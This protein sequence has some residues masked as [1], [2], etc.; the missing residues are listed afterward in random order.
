[1]ETPAS[2]LLAYHA[3]TAHCAARGEYARGPSRLDWKNQPV[4]FRRFRAPA[5]GEAGAVRL[6]ELP[7]RTPARGRRGWSDTLSARVRDTPHSRLW[8][9]GSTGE[10]AAEVV[11]IESAACL[12]INALGLSGR[13]KSGQS[14]WSLRC[15]PSSGN[16]HP[17]EAYV[18]AGNSLL[19]GC[20]S[21]ESGRDRDDRGG[22]DPEFCGH[23]GRVEGGGEQEMAD[24]DCDR[25]GYLFHYEPDHHQL[26]LRASGTLAPGYSI[27]RDVLLV[28]LSS[29]HWREEWKYG[30]RALRYCYLDTGHAVGAL[31][32][33]AALLGWDVRLLPSSSQALSGLLGTDRESDFCE[34]EPEVPL[35]LLACGARN[36]LARIR[37]PAGAAVPAWGSEVSWFGAANPLSKQHNTF[38]LE[39]PSCASAEVSGECQTCF[40]GGG[41]AI[42][43]GGAVRRAA[44]K[45]EQEEEH[46]ADGRVP[47]VYDVIQSRRSALEMVPRQSALPKVQFL[48]MIEHLSRVEAIG[49]VPPVHAFFFAHRV[50]G[51]N[52]GIYVLLRSQSGE[53]PARPDLSPRVAHTWKQV[54]APLPFYQLVTGD[55]RR[56]AATTACVQSIAGN[57]TFA[58]AMVSMQFHETVR[59]CPHAYRL[60]HYDAGNVIH[61]L[62]LDSTARGYATTG[63]GC[64]FDDLVAELLGYDRDQAACLYMGAVGKAVVDDRLTDI[65]PYDPS[66]DPDV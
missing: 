3:R 39:G 43:G 17:V 57:G 60:A 49:S 23:G 26:C 25:D 6:V 15:N 47:R 8:G 56:A 20:P 4:A 24:R 16:L 35:L 14:E 1:M 28:G 55:V 10:L 46:A 37:C 58:V 7:F 48:E 21:A 42:P 61:G 66:A 34:S 54:A 51:L 2:R 5:G 33:S 32:A 64:Y 45:E 18:L 29:I 9:E 52:P 11:S 13:K 22:R 38:G 30:E 53:E 27:P 62:Y 41:G 63:I 65:P 19:A 12:L 50:S 36:A 40:A 44:E 59:R 31:R